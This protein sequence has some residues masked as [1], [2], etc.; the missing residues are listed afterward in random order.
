MGLSRPSERSNARARHMHCAVSAQKIVF[1]I[2]GRR[3]LLLTILLETGQISGSVSFPYPYDQEEV[4]SPHDELSTH[5]M[6]LVGCT[7]TSEAG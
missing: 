4:G 3:S 1:K 5:V 7:T 2:R 6:S